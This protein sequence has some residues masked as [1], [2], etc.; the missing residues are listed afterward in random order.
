[1]DFVW[2]QKGTY[3]KRER[4]DIGQILRRINS[5][6]YADETRDAETHPLS[7]DENNDLTGSFA[8][9]NK[10]V[11]N[12]LDRYGNAI[13]RMG[14]SYLHNKADAEDV[15]QDTLIK[16]MQSAPDFD[17]P[18]HEKAWLLRVTANLSKNKIDYNRIRQAEEIDELEETLMAEEQEDLSFVWEA[19]KA[20]PD[21]YREV[22]HLYYQEGYRTKEISEILGRKESSIRSDLKR[23]RERLKEILKGAYD[24][25]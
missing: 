25:E 3:R 8:V 7:C 20:L 12:V 22:I 6:L 4:R 14:Y 23:G 9:R 15:L 13:L 19:V 10:Q 2:E 21:N 17:S 16:Y 1:M 18:E 5:Y 24:F 11:E